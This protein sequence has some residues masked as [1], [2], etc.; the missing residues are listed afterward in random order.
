MRIRRA[1]V[2]LVS[3]LG[4]KVASAFSKINTVLAFSAEVP[5]ILVPDTLTRGNVASLQPTV[6]DL[7]EAEIAHYLQRIGRLERRDR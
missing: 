3:T 5:Q 6:L 7:R 1:I 2:T 4:G